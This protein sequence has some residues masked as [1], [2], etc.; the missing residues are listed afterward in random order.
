MGRRRLPEDGRDG[1]QSFGRLIE[2]MMLESVA[3]GRLR[4]VKPR[5]FS[6]P[7]SAPCDG[8]RWAPYSSKI[9][10]TVSAASA[11]GSRRGGC[12]TLPEPCGPCDSRRGQSRCGRRTRAGAGDRA[13]RPSVA[14]GG[15]PLPATLR[16]RQRRH[17]GGMTGGR[18][19][20]SARPVA[21]SGCRPTPA[22]PTDAVRP[23]AAS[24]TTPAGPSMSGACRLRTCC[25]SVAGTTARDAAASVRVTGPRPSERRPSNVSLIRDEPSVR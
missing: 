24:R 17:G 19:S 6:S 3:P 2:E 1:Q 21:A 4:F 9:E 25:R 18:R 11:A 15:R 20:G 14:A 12:S 13:S 10:R 16:I 5:V 23:R 22:T 7:A 8:Q